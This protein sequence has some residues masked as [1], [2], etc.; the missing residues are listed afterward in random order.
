MCKGGS[1]HE[2]HSE[3]PRRAGDVDTLPAGV[4]LRRSDL[5]D[6]LYL[7]DRKRRPGPAG[8]AGPAD[9]LCVQ[10]P[11]PP[12]DRAGGQPHRNPHAGGKAA[13]RLAEHQPLAERLSS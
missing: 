7:L 8:C 13:G 3:N 12:G 2:T 4:A 11:D 1:F 9:H 6:G 10:R 5:P